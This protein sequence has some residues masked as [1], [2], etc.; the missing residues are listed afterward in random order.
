[1]VE[2]AEEEAV[3]VPP[4]SSVK[5]LTA[6]LAALESVDLWRRVMG[7]WRGRNEGLDSSSD[8]REEVHGQERL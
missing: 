6:M 7:K 4:T 3:P 1:M 8:N 5:A 2:E